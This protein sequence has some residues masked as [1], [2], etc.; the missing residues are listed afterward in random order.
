MVNEDCK[1]HGI[2]PIV[3]DTSANP[4]G[5]EVVGKEDICTH[6]EHPPTISGLDCTDCPDY[7][8]IKKQK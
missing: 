1:Y 8:P 5:P 4:D 2:K 3:S 6:E 7:E